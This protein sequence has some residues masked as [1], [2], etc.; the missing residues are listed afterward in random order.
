M[1]RIDYLITEARRIGKN[2]AN[3][4]GSLPISD[5]EV[6]Q[7]MNDAQDEMQGLL[8]SIK[9]IDVIFNASQVISVVGAQQNYSIPDRVLLNKQ[10]DLVEFSASGNLGDY[11][12]LEKLS[13]FNQ[14]TNNANYPVGYFRRNN[15]IFLV[16]IPSSSMGSLRVTYERACDD[17]DKRRGTIQSVSGLTSTTFTSLVVDSDADE[18]STP[19][20]SSID[21]I[22]IVDKDGNRKAYNIPVG[23]Y[24]AGTNTLTPAAG[25]VFARSG[26]TIAAGDYIT[27]GKWRTTHSQ[28][29]DECEPYLIYY[30]AE[31]LLHKDSSNDVPTQSAKLRD[32]RNQILKSFASQTGEIQR[33]PQFNR[34][35]WW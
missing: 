8:S 15:Q 20:L 23:N 6:I 29:P 22:C 9:N 16:P 17:L 5:E 11:I 13:S 28:L 7:Y 3:T 26:D 2:E 21:Y 12:I 10:V 27:F 33:I 30:A 4:N 35:D 14:D 24:N 18:T 1:R 25:F 34:Y 31:M 32:L 19:N